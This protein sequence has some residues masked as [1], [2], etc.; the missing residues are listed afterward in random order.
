MLCF[1]CVGTSERVFFMLPRDSFIVFLSCKTVEHRRRKSRDL[2]Q[3]GEVTI[4]F[5]CSCLRTVHVCSPVS[6]PS[7]RTAQG[8]YYLSFGRFV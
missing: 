1:F 4:S 3:T 8:G 5:Q 7:L 6:H 2:L